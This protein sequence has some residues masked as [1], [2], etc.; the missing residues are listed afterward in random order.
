MLNWHFLEIG[1]VLKELNRNP[2]RG[3]SQDGKWM[4]EEDPAEAAFVVAAVKSGLH[5]VEMRLENPRIE[6]IPFSS[7]R[8]RMTTIHQI[9]DGRRVFVEGAMEVV[10]GKCNFIL[11][12]SGVKELKE[13]GRLEILKANEEMAREV[14]QAIKICEQ[15]GVKP[16]MITGDHKLTAMAIAK[17]TDIC[18]EGDFVL[19]GE[20]LEKIQN[21]EFEKKVSRWKKD[22]GLN[23]FPQTINMMFR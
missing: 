18:K 19:T 21:W 15:V 6:E 13:R 16:I 2:Y 14:V 20:G 10:L 17:E 4:I 22:Y 12:D 7:E 23:L 11:D 3:L 8:K 9:Q 1:G 5:Q